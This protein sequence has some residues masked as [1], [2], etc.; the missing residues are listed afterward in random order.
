MI[1]NYLNE[2]YKPFA[3]NDIVQNLH[4]QVSKTNAL[5][6]LEAL[7]ASHR[8]NC[9][10][11]GKIS[12]YIR[13]EIDLEENVGGK[14]YTFEDIQELNEEYAKITSD[15]HAW[16]N[17][18]SALLQEPSNVELGA[19]IK[20]LERKVKELKSNIEYLQKTPEDSAE[21]DLVKFIQDSRAMVEKEIRAR[22]R[23]WKSC[24]QLIKHGIQPKDVNEF[25][26]SCEWF[27]GE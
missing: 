13:N 18:T 7:S 5:K 8:I 10:Q 9:K 15:R 4:S 2:N 17:K 19:K 21:N 25:L 6:A 23:I 22:R 1:L 27:T 11:F 24:V 12:I 16:E 26:V 3:I 20:E 14:E